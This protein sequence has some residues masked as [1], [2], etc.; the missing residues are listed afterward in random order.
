MSQFQLVDPIRFDDTTV[1]FA[2]GI[3]L[4]GP[5]TSAIAHAAA[6]RGV[7]GRRAKAAWGALGARPLQARIDRRTLY[8]RCSIG[9]ENWR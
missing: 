7:N 1:F 9:P 8:D 3:S 5:P 4:W 2:P 6:R